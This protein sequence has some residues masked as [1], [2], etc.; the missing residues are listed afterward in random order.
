M[1]LDRGMMLSSVHVEGETSIGTGFFVTVASDVIEGERHGYVL[2]AHHVIDGQRQVTIRVQ[3]QSGNGELYDPEPITDWRHP[4][5]TLDLALAP[6]DPLPGRQYAA[7]ELE[8]HVIIGPNLGA[9]I[10]YIGLFVA[11]PVDRM[12]ARSGTIGALDQ[13]G[14]PH[15]GPYDYVAHLVD[16][17]S[18]E[19]F[20]GSPCFVEVGFPQLTPSP[21]VVTPPRGMPKGPIGKM[22]YLSLFCGMFTA[23]YDDPPEEEQKEA[24]EVAKPACPKERVISKYGVGVM[25]RSEEIC[26]VL[27]SDALV[28]E[29]REKD[30]KAARD[31]RASGFPVLRKAK[32]N[33]VPPHLTREGFDDAL[34]RATRLVTPSAESAPEG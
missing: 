12:M 14:L 32:K 20:S 1:P 8:N 18:Y 23:H 21:L 5:K 30:E 13:E 6:H 3:H 16:C 2:T 7:V 10:F 27:M 17:R 34:S 26:D 9:P 29:R 33:V 4:V 22:L 11:P 28:T 24:T 19:G 31:R 15:G 25:L